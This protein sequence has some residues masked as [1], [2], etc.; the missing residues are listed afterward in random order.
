MASAAG[1]TGPSYS[2]AF[3]FC[4]NF[5]EL[6]RAFL[7]GFLARLRLCAAY[8][9]KQTAGAPSEIDIIARCEFSWLRQKSVWVCCVENQ[10]PLE[11]LLAGQHKGYGFVMSIDQQQKRVVTDRLAFKSD[12][13]AR[14]AAQ[15]HAEAPN[16]RRCPFFLAHQVTAGIEPHHVPNLGTGD[17][18]TF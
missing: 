1:I 15:Q 8:Q 2:P 9:L 18:A 16:K 12:Y 14:I 7:P 11:I 10:L 4:A 5:G 6:D 3:F 13:I 17:A